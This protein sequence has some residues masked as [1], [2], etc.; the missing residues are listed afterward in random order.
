MSTMCIFH[1]ENEKRIEYFPDR[2][3]M[4]RDDRSFS[5][6]PLSVHSMSLLDFSLIS[7]NSSM[8][9][10]EVETIESEQQL[11]DDKPEVLN[12]LRIWL[13]MAICCFP[14]ELNKLFGIA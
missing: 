3:G 7:D 12:G 10:D 4:Q 9:I 8:E 6:L 11:D 5:P 2:R 14:N 13:R 1:G